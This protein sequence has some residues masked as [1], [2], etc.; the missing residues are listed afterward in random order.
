MNVSMSRQA[1]LS[2]IEILV[3]LVVLSLG[4][5]GVAGVQLS[6]IKF[7]QVSQQRSNAVQLATSLTDRMRSNMPGVGAGNYVF[8]FPY[9]AIPGNVPAAPNCGAP[10]TPQ[11][12][13]SLHLNQW[14]TELA[15][16]LPEGRGTVTQI[17]AGVG[18]PY[19]VTVMWAEKDLTGLG[20][21]ARCP[22]TAPPEAQ[23]LLVEFQP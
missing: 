10:C 11:Q 1:G 19:R 4:A 15:A 2:L 9:A 14:L 13:A 16:A 22:A 18:S 7:N 23:C 12:L 8:N 5:I 6:T 3:A 20:R 17:G 21:D